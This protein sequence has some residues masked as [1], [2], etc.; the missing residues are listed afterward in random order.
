MP[1][2]S[3]RRVLRELSSSLGECTRAKFSP[4]LKMAFLS[5][6]FFELGHLF[7]KVKRDV[8]PFVQGHYTILQYTYNHNGS[9]T[10]LLCTFFN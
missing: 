7:T 10:F 4:M 8:M 6:N 5:S 2:W 3:D 1:R 9:L